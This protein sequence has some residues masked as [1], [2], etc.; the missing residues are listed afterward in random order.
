MLAS[1][2][3]PFVLTIAMTILTGLVYPLV[4]TGWPRSSSHARPTAA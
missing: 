2:D 3:R 4:V 1:F